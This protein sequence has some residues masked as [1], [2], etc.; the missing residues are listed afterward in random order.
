MDI[1]RYIDHARDNISLA[2]FPAGGSG[3]KRVN[4]GKQILF[5]ME[6]EA[7]R[8]RTGGENGEFV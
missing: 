7:R 2:E 5:G 3:E 1:R 8:W 6:R 4:P